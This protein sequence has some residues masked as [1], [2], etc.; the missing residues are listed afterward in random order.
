MSIDFK[1]IKISKIGVEDVCNEWI[2][3]LNDPE[4]NRF[5]EQ[6][7]FTHTLNTQRD[8]VNNKLNEKSSTVY[9]FKVNTSLLGIGE[10]SKIND[11]HKTAEISYLVIEKKIWG[12]GFGSFLVNSLIQI[13][14]EELGLYKLNAGIYKENIG[15]SKVLEKNG[16]KIEGIQ[17]SQL[18]FEGFRTDKVIYGLSLIEDKS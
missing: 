15:S 12:Q 17:G 11:N 1:E 9:K 16:F 8:F 13:A 2:N 3:A 14:R 10:I 6:R 4:V 7:F 5:S 18:S